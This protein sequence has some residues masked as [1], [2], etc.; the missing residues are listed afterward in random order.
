M[1]PDNESSLKRYRNSIY[2]SF[3]F[4]VAKVIE[5]LLVVVKIMSNKFPDARGEGQRLFRVEYYCGICG[6]LVPSDIKV[7]S[8]CSSSTS[9]VQENMLY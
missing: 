7:V 5:L 2:S 4:A 3:S 8:V 9:D 6:S 1:R